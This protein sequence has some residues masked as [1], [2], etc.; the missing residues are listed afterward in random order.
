M[1]GIPAA[2]AAFSALAIAGA[3]DGATA[4]PSTPWL[5]RSWT[6]WSCSSSV[7]SPGPMYTHSMSAS[8]AC[9]L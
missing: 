9:A 2:P 8:S 7:C 3:L 5:M 1:T 4:I 6:I